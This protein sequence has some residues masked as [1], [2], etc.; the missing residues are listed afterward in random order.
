MTPQVGDY[1]M[2]Q[3]MP[4]NKRKPDYYPLS[5]F[6]KAYSHGHFSTIWNNKHHVIKIIKNSVYI[7]IDGINEDI[8]IY[9]EEIKRVIPQD[10][11]MMLFEL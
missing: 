4:D 6:I 2:L 3:D 11:Q 9:V 7:Y 8:L 5:K 10:R 1:V